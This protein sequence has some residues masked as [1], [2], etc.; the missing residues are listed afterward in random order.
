MRYL[1]RR[2]PDWRNF[3]GLRFKTHYI[4][5]PLDDLSGG[6]F[7]YMENERMLYYRQDFKEITGLSLNL[8]YKKFKIT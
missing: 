6:I 1:R 4:K 3:S 8:L 7:M 5:I 2:L